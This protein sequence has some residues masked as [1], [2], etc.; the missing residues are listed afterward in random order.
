MLFR[1]PGLAQMR[2]NFPVR[3]IF[4]CHLDSLG[5]HGVENSPPRVIIRGGG[6]IR[7]FVSR[8]RSLMISKALWYDDKKKKGSNPAKVNH[9]RTDKKAS[10]GTEKSSF[11]SNFRFGSECSGEY[12]WTRAAAVAAQRVC[13]V[14]GSVN[15]RT[16]ERASCTYTRSLPPSL[17]LYRPLHPFLSPPSLTPLSSG[18]PTG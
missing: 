1:R 4:L 17:P 14:Y 11:S 7:S 2:V 9:P 3:R 15:T 6:S 18:N 8:H 12:L 5:R 10:L 16:S 13:C